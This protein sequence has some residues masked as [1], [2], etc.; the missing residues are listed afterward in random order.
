MTT[1]TFEALRRA[2][3]R[4]RA[5][6]P[7]TVE[8]LAPV[9]GA[10]IDV[11]TLDDAPPARRPKHVARVGAAGAVV[12][13]AAAVAVFLVVSSSGRTPGVEDAAAAVAKAAT[14][15]AAS[16]ER[17][18]TAVV[19]MTHDGEPWAGKSIRWNGHDLETMRDEAAG[20]ASNG[21]SSAACSTAS[22]RRPTAGW[23]SVPPRTSTPTAA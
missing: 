2:N 16:A 12:A 3:P 17:S 6:F 19:R 21:C 20:P 10:R 7:Q 11:T 15:T 18:G 9:V 14:L 8:A 5:D 13:V 4:L 22:T 1:D 23:S